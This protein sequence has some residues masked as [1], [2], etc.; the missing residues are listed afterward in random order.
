MKNISQLQVSW[1]DGAAWHSEAFSGWPGLSQRLATSQRPEPWRA[2]G[3][4][5]PLHSRRPSLE[6]PTQ[7]GQM[8]SHCQN[9]EQHQWMQELQPR[10][11]ELQSQ[12]VNRRHQP[13]LPKVP[14]HHRQPQAQAVNLRWQLEKHHLQDQH[15][16]RP[17]HHV[18]DLHLPPLDSRGV[19]PLLLQVLLDRPSSGKATQYS[20][21]S[22]RLSPNFKRP[23]VL[24]ALYIYVWYGKLVTGT[25][26]KWPRPKQNP[27][28]TRKR[29]QKPTKHLRPGNLATGEL[30][31]H[32]NAEAFAEPRFE[33]DPLGIRH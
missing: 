13:H 25:K 7:K 18:L 10:R 20:R 28:L 1:L 21:V 27:V 30:P 22:T 19:A 5:S 33:L 17:S 24:L 4:P 3:P 12:R 32:Q 16:H 11:Q 6:T 26:S 14:S 23:F 2:C 9:L 29:A 8:A 31:L 15:H